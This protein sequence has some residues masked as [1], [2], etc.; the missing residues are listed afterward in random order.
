MKPIAVLMDSTC[1]LNKQTMEEFKIDYCPMGVVIDEKEYPA[2]LTWKDMSPT[3]FYTLMEEGKRP[4]TQQVTEDTYRKKFQEYLA[5]GMD[6]LYIGCS[7]ALSASVK[8]AARIA[9]EMMAGDTESKII[10]VDSLNASMGQ[11][12]MGIHAAE[13]RDEGHSI[14][15][16]AAEI[17]KTK[18]KYNQWGTSGTL[19]YLKNAGRVKA[20]A[21]FFGDII[22]VKPIIISDING[23]NFAYKKVRGRKNSL[24]EVADSVIATSE[25]PEKHY[26]AITHANCLDDAKEIVRLVEQKIHFKRVF[27]HD[28]GPILGASCGPNMVAAYNYGKEV[29]LQGE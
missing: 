12:L 26:L 22:G 7:G 21:A 8:V 11:G 24:Q 25:D 6:I 23:N 1:D 18:L 20:S 9:K 13:M 19:K 16:I 10:V 17:E 28:M 3:Q 14:D 27:I 4:Y 15:E 5:Q 2:D 29:T